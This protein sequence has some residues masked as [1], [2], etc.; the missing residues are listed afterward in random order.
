MSSLPQAASQALGWHFLSGAASLSISA[1]DFAPRELPPCAAEA[2]VVLDLAGELLDGLAAAGLAPDARWQW[3]AQG[4]G[5]SGA[6]AQALWRGT[7]AQARLTLPW[8]ALRA[9]AEAPDVPGLLWQATPAEHLLAQWQLDDDEVAALES[10][11]LLLLEAP[12]CGR[13]RARGEAPE[14]LTWQLVSRWEQPLPAALVMGWQGP[15]PLPPAPCQLIEAARPD[16]VRARG[17]LLPWGSGHAFRID[18][19]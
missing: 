1:D 4:G 10:G 13:M 17:R 3:V 6:Q 9:L 19:I 18:T 14:G 8:A 11:G 12:V 2:A 16:A 5:L 7:E 15:A